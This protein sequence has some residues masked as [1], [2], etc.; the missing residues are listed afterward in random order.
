MDRDY[1]EGMVGD[2]VDIFYSIAPKY[3]TKEALKQTLIKMLIE[4]CLPDKVEAEALKE[5]KQRW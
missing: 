5:A 4:Q 2:A 3:R 1:I